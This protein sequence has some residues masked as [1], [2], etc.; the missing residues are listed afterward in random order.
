MPA[1]DIVIK[2][3]PVMVR[4]PHFASRL[5]LQ[6]KTATGLTGPH[7]QPGEQADNHRLAAAPR[8]TFTQANSTARIGQSPADS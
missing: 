8:P 6:E 7:G 3:I 4:Q 2:M 5:H 1:D